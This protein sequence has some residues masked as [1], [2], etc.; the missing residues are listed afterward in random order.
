[1]CRTITAVFVVVFVAAAADTRSPYPATDRILRASCRIFAGNARGSGVIFDSDED[2]YHVLTNAH[3]VGRTGNRVNVEFEHSGYRSGPIHGR[4]SCCSLGR[5]SSSERY[6]AAYFGAG[7]S[8]RRRGGDRHSRQSP[9]L[10]VPML[11]S[12]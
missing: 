3:V 4:P 10:A 7:G 2:N 11:V 8:P 9:D 6:A 12:F 5:S 1:M